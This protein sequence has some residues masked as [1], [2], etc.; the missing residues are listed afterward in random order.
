MSQPHQI[1]V[2]FPPEVLAEIEREAK[3]QDRSLP[4]LMQRAWKLAKEELRK[5]P[6]LSA[7]EESSP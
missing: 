3:R 2:Y 5:V 6:P 1:T 7:S 4:W